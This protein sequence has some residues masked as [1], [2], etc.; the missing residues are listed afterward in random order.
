MENNLWLRVKFKGSAGFVSYDCSL[1]SIPLLSILK[2]TPHKSMGQSMNNNLL[3]VSI[4][5]SVILGAVKLKEIK[6][7]PKIVVEA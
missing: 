6:K 1:F 4:I 7:Q 5:L 3:S 2:D